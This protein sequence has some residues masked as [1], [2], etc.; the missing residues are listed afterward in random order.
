MLVY[1]VFYV[2]F[3]DEDSDVTIHIPHYLVFVRENSDSYGIKAIHKD[4]PHDYKVCRLNSM[5]VYDG[6]NTDGHHWAYVYR[7]N[8]WWV[9]D[10]DWIEQ[11]DPPEYMNAYETG[12]PF[13]LVYEAVG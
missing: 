2:T 3:P 9:C 6:D 1:M 4:A 7:N 5:T 12:V 11:E 8:G 10:D 13:S